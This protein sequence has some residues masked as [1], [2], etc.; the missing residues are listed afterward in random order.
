MTSRLFR[1]IASDKTDMTSLHFRS[2]T[3]DKTDM[4]GLIESV[5]LGTYDDQYVAELLNTNDF[6]YFVA[7]RPYSN[8]TAANY[9]E[10]RQRVLAIKEAAEKRQPRM[11]RLVSL[12]LRLILILISTPR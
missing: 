8:M 5:L 10:V 12:N 2:I 3:S 9:L 11:G 6:T 7:A 4:A 1:S